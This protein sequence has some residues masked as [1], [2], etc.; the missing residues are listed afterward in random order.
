MAVFAAMLLMSL[1][2]VLASRNLIMYL[3]ISSGSVFHDVVWMASLV[4]ISLR[5][6]LRY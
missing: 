4:R 5:L 1:S 3:C 2:I 6:C